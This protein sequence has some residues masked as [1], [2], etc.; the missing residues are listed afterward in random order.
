MG[1][2]RNRY[3]SGDPVSNYRQQVKNSALKKKKPEKYKKQKQISKMMA[4]G[5]IDKKE[6]QKAARKGI[7][8]QKIQNQ[9]IN[10]YRSAASEYD[11]RD[12]ETTYGNSTRRPT[13]EPLK[14]KRGAI[15][16]DQGRSRNS[17]KKK[18]NKKRKVTSNQPTTVTSDY[19]NQADKQLNQ[20]DRQ[21][22]DIMGTSDRE[23]PDPLT[24]QYAAS[25]LVDP[26]NNLTI[27]AATDPSKATG[28]DKF[29]RRRRKK[30]SRLLKQI[31]GGGLGNL[32]AGAPAAAAA[33]A[34]P[35]AGLNV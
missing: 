24:F 11:Q 33:S 3:S 14:I 23:T 31:G 32:N 16:A 8:L 7:S 12:S 18:K 34:M 26:G 22:E 20:I 2:N 30:K 5:K 25:S 9:N 6:G 27:A 10:H 13:F 4:D 35:S 17:N 29:K 15:E 19:Q 28:A 1:K 21:L